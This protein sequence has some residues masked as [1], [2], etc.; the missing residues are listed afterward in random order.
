M[1]RETKF[2]AWDSKNKKWLQSVP[3]LE[4]LL[5]DPDEGVSHHDITEEVK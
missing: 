2:R 1:N 5:D 4:Y 3:S